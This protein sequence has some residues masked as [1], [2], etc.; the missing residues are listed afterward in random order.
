M[1]ERDSGPRP[2]AKKEE[3]GK[4][5]AAPVFAGAVGTQDALRQIAL[6]R[7]GTGV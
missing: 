5:K 6:R 2:E 1:R 7:V 4:E 3:N